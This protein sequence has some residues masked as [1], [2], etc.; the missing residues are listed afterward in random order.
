MLRA[1]IIAAVSSPD[2]ATEEKESLPEQLSACRTAC[3]D[4]GWA[5][6]REIVIPGH[7]REYWWLD[8]I[9]RDC[10]EYAEMIDLIRAEQIDLVV[11]WKLDR[12]ARTVS[13]QA[14][15]SAVCAEHRCQIYS[16]TQPIEPLPPEQVR[17]RRG[18]RGILD[19]FAAAVSEEEQQTRVDRLHMGMVGRIRQ[20]LP[21][22]SR[23]GQYGYSPA[24][25]STDVPTVN[26]KQ[27]KWVRWIF[28]RRARGWGYDKVAMHL[29]RLGV[30]S[31]RGGEW[32]GSAIRHI[33]H[34]PLYRGAVRWGQY[35]N[36]EGRHQAIVDADLWQRAQRVEHGVFRRNPR[37]LTGLAKCGYCGWN[38]LYWNPGRSPMILRCSRYVKYHGA[39]C[40]SNG[41]AAASVEAYVLDVVRE[42]L[43]DPDLYADHL[44][45]QRRSDE[46]DAGDLARSLDRLTAAI[47]RWNR[48]Y[49]IGDIGRLEWR[50]HRRRLEAR[51][52]AVE[53]Q[54]RA[55][56]RR[57]WQREALDDRLTDLKAVLEDL[58]TYTPGE[59]NEFYRQIIDRVMC[60]RG[61]E[62]E[63]YLL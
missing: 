61:Q 4:H 36:E 35:V 62:P 58:D 22:H 17:R 8:E 5:V 31:P 25:R 44:R 9:V 12:I 23:L 3:R 21:S 6:V 39:Q 20:G 43:H 37:A 32:H 47:E 11:C 49:E 27:A 16:T 15:L 41:M 53:A 33:V 2:Q 52:G 18:L 46:P 13:L 54:L 40:R 14:Q 59:M 24:L 45:R 38:M 42:L 48:A 7:S 51:I 1:L 50:E 28:E 56:E 55:L 63:I 34:N 57:Q 26:E 30:P 29:N 10:P 19:I 60:R